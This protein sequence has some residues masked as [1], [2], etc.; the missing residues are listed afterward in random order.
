[1]LFLSFIVTIFAW[2]VPLE[3]NYHVT[4]QF[5]S[6]VNIQKITTNSKRCIYH[7]DHK[8]QKGKMVVWGDSY[9]SVYI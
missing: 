6:W 4:Q 7:N 2:N 5:S 1:M 9:M 3:K 8:Q